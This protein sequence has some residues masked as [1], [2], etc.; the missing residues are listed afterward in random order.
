MKKTIR[1]LKSKFLSSEGKTKSDMPGIIEAS[2]SDE[3]SKELILKIVVLESYGDTEEILRLLRSGD[4]MV[5]VKI[6]P[7]REK[8]MSE[9]KRSINRLK[10]HCT[11]TDAQLAAL[12]DSWVIIVPPT[13]QLERSSLD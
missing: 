4:T 7:L 5:V 11:A 3:Q 13:I 8:D 9:L 6:R 2:I 10:T 1:N 12:D